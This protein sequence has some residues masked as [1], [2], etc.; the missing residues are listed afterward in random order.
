MFSDFRI[1]TVCAGDWK[2][3]PFQP[4]AQQPYPIRALKKISPVSWR[5]NVGTPKTHILQSNQRRSIPVNLAS[6]GGAAR[7]SASW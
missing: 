5:A 3:A 2:L 4:L 6:V 1:E 7:N